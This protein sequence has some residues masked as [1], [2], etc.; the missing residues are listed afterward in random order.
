MKSSLKRE[1]LRVLQEVFRLP[2]YRPGQKEAV[3]ALLSGRD[4]LC[5]LPTGA[6]KSLCWQIPAVISKRTTIVVSPLIA[7]MRDQVQHLNACGIPAE[8]LDSLMTPE[9]REEAISRIRSGAVRIVFVSP[10][11]LLQQQFRRLCLQLS[12]GMIVI[13]EAHCVVQWGEKFRPSYAEIPAFVSSLPVRPVI[14]ALTA[15]A[16]GRMQRSIMKQVGMRRPKR[17]MLPVVR[18]NLIYQVC[19][20]LDRTRE[21]LRICGGDQGKTVIFCRTRSRAE[22]LALIIRQRG[23][24]SAC[25]HAG[26]DREE[27]LAVQQRFADGMLQ[28][29][30]ATTAFGMGV[31]IPDIR[32]IIH[33]ELPE[34]VYDYAQQTGRA[35]RDGLQSECI[36]LLEPNALVRRSS[37]RS[38]SKNPVVRWRETNRYVRQ[39]EKLLQILLSSRCIPGALAATFGTPAEACGHCSACR[40]GRLVGHAPRYSGRRP[41]DLRLWLLLW[42]RKKLAELRGC[43]PREIISDQALNTAAGKLVFPVGSTAPEEMERLLA[44]FRRYGLNRDGGED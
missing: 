6:G 20:T 22:Y 4:V 11:R 5:V 12:P 36:V 28:I 35:G 7:L 16:D 24:A 43:M 27:R 15:T 30:C 41:R 26:L 21:L 3:H 39:T 38:Y 10:E 25:Y 34:H 29:L 19:T 33:D 14:C 18:E 31:D 37:F 40:H 23:I 32:R 2:A 9:E 17:V 1:C 42:Q 13:D 8:A 44:H